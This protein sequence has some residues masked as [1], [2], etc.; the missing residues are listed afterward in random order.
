VLGVDPTILFVIQFLAVA[1]YLDDDRVGVLPLALED[2]PGEMTGFDTV[3]SMGVLY[4]RRSPVGHLHRLRRLLRLGGELILETLVVEGAEDQVLVPSGR[5]ARM[6]NVWFIPSP[7]ALVIWLGRCG[8]RRAR[9]IDVSATTVEEQR[10]TEWMRF[11][12][13]SDCLDPIDSGRTLEGYPA[14]RRAILV[15]DR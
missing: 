3:F 4:H 8:F 9:V 12:S 14:P 11:Q 6:R 10:S 1:G 5:Y 2:L 7:R 15:A 13:L